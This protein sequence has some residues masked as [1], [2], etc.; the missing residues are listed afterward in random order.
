MFSPVST[1][2]LS[3]VETLAGVPLEQEPLPERATFG[4]RLRLMA[5]IGLAMMLHARLKLLA[6]LA[7]VVFSVLLINFAMGTFFGLLEKHTMLSKN[8][9]ADVW[10]VPKG[11]ELLGQGML[12][13]HSLSVARTTPGVAEAAPLL[14]GGS[15]VV[16]PGGRHEGITLIGTPYPY[17]L[18][19]P[20][21]LV[22]GSAAAL[23]QPDTI[24]L[25]GSVRENFGGVNMGSV[26]EVGGRRTVIGGFTWGLAGIGASYAFADYETA[27]DYLH[28]RNDRASFVVVRVQQ[29]T[30]PS[31]VAEALRL[32]ANNVDV[33]TTEALV[34]RGQMQMLT[35][36]PVGVTFASIS[37]FG[38][39]IGMV[40]VGL[41]MLS[42]VVDSIREFGMLKAL[43]CTSADIALLLAAQSTIVGLLG[44]LIG[45]GALSIIARAM[46]SPNMGLSLPWQLPAGTVIAMV[47]MCLAASL[48]SLLRI[49]K[50]EPAMVFR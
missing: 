30:N 24:I 26:R 37:M 42:A 6:T 35:K 28:A 7:G 8:A 20:W 21:N 19:G 13:L 11:A 39:L 22:A 16:I 33:Y 5:E 12:D 49:R 9:G 29:G 48:F 36:T 10:I 2:P 45:L 25:E 17:T 1:N 23:R 14:L 15:D 38:L 4:A 27:R 50:V 40:I 44:S 3:L 47:A 32:R 34:R 46:R 18:G 41:T 43:G 31:E